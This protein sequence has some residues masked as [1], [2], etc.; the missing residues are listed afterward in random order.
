MIT[1]GLH[2]PTVNQLLIRPFPLRGAWWLYSFDPLSPRVPWAGSAERRPAN[3]FT[4]FLAT[5]TVFAVMLAEMMVLGRRAGWSSTAAAPNRF[6][7]VGG[8]RV[9]YSIYSVGA[10]TGGEQKPGFGITKSSGGSDEAFENRCRTARRHGH[11][12]ATSRRQ[13]RQVRGGGVES[14]AFEGRG[15]GAAGTYDRII[16]RATIA[17]SPGSAQRRHRRSTARRAMRRDWSRPRRR[18]I[19]GRPLRPMAT[20]SCSMT[21]SIAAASSRSP[22]QRCAGRQRPRQG[23]RRGQRLPDEPRLHHHVE[24]L[25]GRLQAG[26]GRA[27]LTR[28]GRAGDVPASRARNSSSTTRRTR[29]A[30]R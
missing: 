1:V 28:P 15:F 12:R 24:R 11:V 17:V 4:N 25:A 3:V 19:C 7:E 27:I 22:A 18:E 29:S 26:G 6:V 8:H 9:D 13:G 5:L 10:F 20:A 14:P 2:R 21:W 30:R 23:R 16:A